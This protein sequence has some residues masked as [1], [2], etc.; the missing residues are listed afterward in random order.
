MMLQIMQWYM[1]P[2]SSYPK[3]EAACTSEM[4]A[5]PTTTTRFSNPTTEITS[6]INYR[7]SLKSI[8][9]F[10]YC[11]MP[12]SRSVFACFAYILYTFALQ[13]FN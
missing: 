8:R 7:E 3:M 9:T 4:S 13:E 11:L 5:T 6:I 10:Y 12:G 2:P 1:P